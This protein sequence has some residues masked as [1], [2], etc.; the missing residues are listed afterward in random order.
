M[1]FIID[2]KLVE[3]DLPPSLWFIFFKDELLAESVNNT[4]NIPFIDNIFQM[5]L[6]LSD[7]TYIGSLDGKDCY[8]ASIDEKTDLEG[9]TFSKLLP[10]YDLMDEK[11]F[12]IAGRAYHLLNWAKNNR[13]CS[14][15]GSEMADVH[16]ERAKQCSACSNRIYPR[17]SPAVIVAITRGDEILL[18]RGRRHTAPMYS[19][20][21]GF[22]EP[23][24]TLEECVR[25]EIREEVGLEVKNISYFCSQPWPFPDSLM[26][27]FTAEYSSGDIVIDPNEI[28][29]AGWYKADSMPQIPGRKGIAARKL[30]DWFRTNA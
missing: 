26:V 28:A 24:E 14:I 7:I 11:I 12:W 4:L 29:E 1:N 2:Y 21:A 9:Y 22:V 18:A 19:C 25:R 10:S 30:I 8:A 17:I 13:F 3:S 27:G 20:I 6:K 5:G 16:E 15:C 23:G